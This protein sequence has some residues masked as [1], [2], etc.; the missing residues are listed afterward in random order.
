MAR[1]EY[2]RA[3]LQRRLASYG[4]SEEIGEL[5]GQL[6]AEGIVSDQRVA[7]S[8]V[9]S[10]A[11]RM[12]TTRLRQ[13]LR[14]KG[15]SRE[16]IDAALAAEIDT[17]TASELDRARV[18]WQRKFGQVPSNSSEYG[19]QARF[20]QARGFSGEVIRRLLHAPRC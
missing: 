17:S 5:L 15:V 18:V 7:E 1:R 2:S 3:E 13:D 8:F 14:A 4:D 10:R 6:E 11:V 16:L 20:L 12:G 19:R 9:R